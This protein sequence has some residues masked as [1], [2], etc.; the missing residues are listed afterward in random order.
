MEK[1]KKQKPFGVIYKATNVLNGKSYIGQ[2]VCGYKD[3]FAAHVRASMDES[4]I[5]FHRAL[6]KYGHENFKLSVVASAYSKQDL[7]DKE[8]LMIRKHRTMKCG[9]NLTPGGRS[10]AGDSNPNYG[11]KWT[12]KQRS[13]L[14]VMR[15]GTKSSEE[16]RRRVSIASTGRK[17]SEESKRKISD[18]NKGSNN[19]MFGKKQSRESNDKRSKTL[20]GRV[21]S[22]DHKRRIGEGNRRR[23]ARGEFKTR[24]RDNFGKFIRSA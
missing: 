16:T 5:Y 11:N 21:F 22:L 10:L 1:I 3:R 14:S 20:K 13:H 24:K 2:T 9:Y 6:R 12:D 18:A 4:D 17:H 15:K 23:A 19:H 7:E 8:I